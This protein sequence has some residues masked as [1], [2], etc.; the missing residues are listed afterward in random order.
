VGYV[1]GKKHPSY[2]HGKYCKDYH[3]F[4]G[5]GKLLSRPDAKMC[6]ECYIE[7]FKGE[8]NPFVKTH[9]K[10]ETVYCIDCGIE[11]WYNSKQ[12]WDCYAKTHKGEN[13]SF[14]GKKHKPESIEKMSKA[15]KGKFAGDKHPNWQEGISKL[16]YSF[17]FTPA[18]KKEIIERDNY[19]CQYCEITQEE[20]FEKYNR[21][22][23]IHHIDYNKDNCDKI[24]LMALCSKC[25]S[26]VNYNRDYWYAYFTY[27]I[28]EK[29]NG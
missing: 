17:E 13:H 12:C 24:N 11:I 2:K 8:T 7:T 3:S 23:L 20:H 4:C 18:L 14:Y 26:M 1:M 25:N 19:K 28:E 27:K 16:P 9:G 15:K 21:D 5:C 10:A 6:K 22:I 29:T